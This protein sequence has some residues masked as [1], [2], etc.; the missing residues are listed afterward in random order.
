MEL[1]L[2]SSILRELILE[3]DR[4]SLPGMG[5]FIAEMAPSVFSDRAMVIHP[6]YRRILFRTAEVW[7]DGLLEN[8]YAIERGIS[9]ND[10]SAEIAEFVKWLKTELNASKSYKIPDFG[11]MRATEQNDYFFVADK[12]LFNYPEG[13][14]LEPINLKVLSKKGV[15]ETLTGKSVPFSIPPDGASTDVSD[16][17]KPMAKTEEKPEITVEA[18]DEVKPELISE[19]TSELKPD[20]QESTKMTESEKNK[21]QKPTVIIEA[22]EVDTKLPDKVANDKTGSSSKFVR[23]FI[24]ILSII[25]LVITVIA[26][27][28]IFKDDLRP[29][30]EWLLYTKEERE[31]LHELIK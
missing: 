23:R 26:L 30:W 21:P 24:V 5:S 2:I 10:A 11:T 1:N 18:N 15:V 16:V 31:I 22:L 12:G 7:N 17:Q 4:V 27:L 14:G 3:H 20:S 29:F 25:L 28:F 6:P 9:I 8:R 13:F 19:T